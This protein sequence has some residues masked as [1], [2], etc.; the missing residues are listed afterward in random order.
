VAIRYG[1]FIMNN[2]Q[3][4][5]PQNPNFDGPSWTGEDPTIK[6]VPESMSIEPSSAP[7]YVDEFWTEEG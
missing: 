6:T 4:T 7:A 1:T 5:P 3:Y 2:Q